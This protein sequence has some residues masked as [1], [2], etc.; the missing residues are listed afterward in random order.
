MAKSRVEKI[1]GVVKLLIN[2]DVVP[3]CAYTTYFDER[4]H[5]EDFT[6]A[7]YQLYSVT[8][9]FASRALN[10]FTGF[11]PY[12]KGIFDK[13]T[14]ESFLNNVLKRGGTEHPMTLYKRFRGQEPTID[15]MLERNGIK[16]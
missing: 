3:S 16:R 6:N 7:G 11:T 8:I 12:E 4:N 13:E 2:D 10:A 15:A 9:A 1:N 5:Y 14:A